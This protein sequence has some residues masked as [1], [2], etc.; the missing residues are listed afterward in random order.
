[1]NYQI[2]IDTA[3]HYIR[4]SL[5]QSNIDKIQDLRKKAINVYERLLTSIQITEYLLIDNNP[6][7]P[8]QVY[9]EAIFNTATLYKTITETEI[10]LNNNVL[11]P[12]YID[13]FKKAIGLFYTILQIV[14]EDIN[15]IKQ[16]VS[17]YTILCFFSQNN[18]QQCLGFLQ[19]S[20]LYAS[21]NALIHYNLGFVYQRLN[22]IELSIIHYKISL[23]LLKNCEMTTESR[24]LKLNNLNGI[25]C[26]YRSIKRWPESLYYLQQ[27]ELI[28]NDDPDILNQLGI[29]Y[30][31]MRRTDIAEQCYKRALENTSKCF[32]SSDPI[33]L[34]A[35]IYLNYGHMYSYNGDNESAVD[36]YNK[37]LKILPTFNL[38]FQNKI[39]NLNYLFDR[40]DDKMYITN[41]HK[42]VNKLY[43]SGD[44]K[45][46]SWSKSDIINIGI[47][48]GD[49]ID[50]PVSFFIST[51]LKLY[52]STKFSVTCYSE[53]VIDTS[54]FNKNIKFK[55][56]RNMS[57]HTAS[58]LIYNDHIHILF[59]LAGHT[60]FN[61]MDIFAKKPSPIQI[62]YIGYPFTTGLNT[63]DYRITDTICDNIEISQKYYT[64]TLLPLDNCFLCY[65]PDT[66]KR[67]PTGS[68]SPFVLPE[69]TTK[70]PYLTTRSLYIGCFNR[71]NK[72]TDNVIK[73]FN[74]ILLT[75]PNVKFVF[76]TK[77]LINTNIKESF[78]NKFDK[79]VVNNIIILDCT[80]LHVDHLLEYNKVD[81][82]IDTFPYSGTTTTCEAL[83][84]GVPVFTLYDSE[85]S[86]HPQNVSASILQNSDL[87][88]YVCESSQE[89]IDKIQILLNKPSSFWDTLKLDTRQSFLNGKV[90][91]SDLY[92]KNFQNLLLRLYSDTV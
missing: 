64:E 72:I 24:Q 17:I 54:I 7:V 51:F 90:C 48:S 75:F 78:L 89:I 57:A 79:S 43:S 13:Q 91:D 60:A 58:E 71:I 62:S 50:H 53:C 28:V 38:P 1:M 6:D 63:M 42:L 88:F 76:K 81:I 32:I 16:I 44:F 3:T 14:F 80:I 82:A 70:Q 49:F 69:L 45:F 39:M 15:S 18:L 65:N 29:V 46:D 8:Q 73:L 37:S 59:D 52:D 25:S 11:K 4:Q 9:I 19:E 68:I 33:F 41:Q 84:Q 67:D 23:G 85:Y 74:K 61:R 31:E 26:V 66:F 83:L 30:T 22:R 77:A 47:V 86:F 36:C 40:F 10:K 20:L 35:E 55:V 92:M 34:K 2:Y 56:I 87:S 5:E 21:D 12:E 27:A